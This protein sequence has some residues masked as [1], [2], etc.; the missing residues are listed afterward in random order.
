MSV[1]LDV[2]VDL[3][4][5]PQLI[6]SYEEALWN[7]EQNLVIKGKRLEEA[8]SENASWQSY[9]DQRRIELGSLVKFVEMKLE[10]VKGQL[11]KMYTEVHSR[12]LSSRD[13]DVYI[14]REPAY[15]KIYQV[16]IIVEELYK[17][18]ASVVDSFQSRGYALRNITN[19]R[20][21]AMEDVVI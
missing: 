19:I 5:I 20:V 9:Y 2:D 21:S 6:I 4:N 7:F 12:E 15:L 1:I 17:K 11:W 3:G 18:F 8:N 16:Y 14:K 10:E 13:K